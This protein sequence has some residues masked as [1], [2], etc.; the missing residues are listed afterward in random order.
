MT[1]A[2]EKKVVLCVDD[3]AIILLAMKQELKLSL[4][5]GVTIDTCSRA[6]EALERIDQYRSR[7]ARVIVIISDWLMPGMSGDEF[8][9]Q[10]HERYPEIPVIL[11]TGQADEREIARLKAT[12]GLNHV[13]KKPWS[14][15]ALTSI[16]KSLAGTEN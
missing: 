9:G 14:S 7:E 4:G 5:N 2:S 16:V 10:V 8:L 3:E 11:V 12:I 13:L 15:A 6:A 1:D